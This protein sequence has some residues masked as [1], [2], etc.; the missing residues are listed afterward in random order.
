MTSKLPA[1][2]LSRKF[3]GRR[4]SLIL[5]LAAL[6]IGIGAVV[7]VLKLPIYLDSI[8]IVIAAMVLG[9]LPAVLCAA[10]TC[11]VGFFLINPYLP[12]YF[13]TSVVIALLATV[14]RR[15]NLFRSL[16]LAVLSGLIIAVGAALASAPITAILFGGT[17]LSGA[18][19]ITAFFVSSGHALLE[20]VF[21]AGLM[22]E[23]IDKVLVCLVAFGVLRSLPR[24]FYNRNGIRYYRHERT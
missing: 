4:M 17:T 1:P 7:S 3:F 24:S 13:G 9:L 19:A 14:C 12:A 21:Y 8:G 15:A 5:A 20:S 11:A 6:N 16:P 18:D 2:L 22:S 23:P 10:I